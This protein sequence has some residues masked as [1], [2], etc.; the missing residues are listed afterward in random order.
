MDHIDIGHKRV[1][2]FDV[3]DAPGEA[4]GNTEV[5]SAASS[6]GERVDL[7]ESGIVRALR[8]MRERAV[9]LEG[10]VTGERAE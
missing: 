6:Q 9:V 5:V 8:E 1:G 4:S 2:V 3:G 10:I 7:I